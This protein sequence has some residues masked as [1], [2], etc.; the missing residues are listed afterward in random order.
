VT[1]S[2]EIDMVYS[3]TKP[4]AK[5][6]R[7]HTVEPLLAYLRNGGRLTQY[8][9]DALV[10]L[11]DPNGNSPWQ[12]KLVRRDNRFLKSDTK[13]D[14]HA[15]AFRRVQTYTNAVLSKTVLRC[16]LR[17]LPGWQL[18]QQGSYLLFKHRRVTQLRI[19]SGKPLS[20][21]VAI[22]IAAFQA[23]MSFEAAKKMVRETEAAL[24]AK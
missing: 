10:D 3:L 9:R 16:V 22:R 11:L 13:V 21:T 20:K 4:V 18:Q 17:S 1:G 7:H 8:G 12:M 2:A 23:K 6:Q 14:V 5:G 24:Q 19:A 15:L